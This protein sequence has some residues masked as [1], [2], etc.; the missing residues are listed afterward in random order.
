MNAE[1]SKAEAEAE[2]SAAKFSSSLRLKRRERCEKCA[3]HKRTS[4]L[5]ARRN[6]VI[7]SLPRGEG[8]LSSLRRR[9]GEHAR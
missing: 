1:G 7:S 9:T 5:R 2:G 6:P 3:S 8:C 4:K